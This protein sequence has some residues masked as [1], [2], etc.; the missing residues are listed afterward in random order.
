[1]IDLLTPTEAAT[2]LKVS[3][4]LVSCLCARGELPGARKVGRFWRIPE[5]TL[6]EYFAA[7]SAKDAPASD[8]AEEPEPKPVVQRARVEKKARKA[9][10]RRRILAGL[11]GACRP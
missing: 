3:P 7:G 4:K 2:I 10:E 11:R 8:D 9:P 5:A 6:T 1:M